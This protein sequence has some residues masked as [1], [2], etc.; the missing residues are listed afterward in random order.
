ME[1]DV[2][3]SL[4]KKIGPLPGYAYVVIGVGAVLYWKKR[5]GS[6]PGVSV[7]STDSPG[8]I[9]VNPSAASPLDG[10]LPLD[11][12]AWALKAAQHLGLTSVNT[13]GEISTALSNYVNGYG[14]T[15]AQQNI[16]DQAIHAQGF[17]SAGL[18]PVVQPEAPA[19]YSPYSSDLG[20]VP[21]PTTNNYY[22]YPSPTP[23]PTP[24]PN[25]VTGSIISIPNFHTPA[26]IPSTSYVDTTG[27]P[28]DYVTINPTATK[29]LYV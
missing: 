17:P 29:Q 7:L 25:S 10:T 28:G 8:T 27:R 13:P 6:T 12:N 3:D 22:S 9:G 18:L 4:T 20:V 15:S 26:P 5:K 21:S 1:P 2:V 11:N 24:A 19:T 14:L 16:V 23:T